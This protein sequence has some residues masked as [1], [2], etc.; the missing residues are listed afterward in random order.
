MD[1]ESFQ[2]APC[3]QCTYCRIQ[4]AAS[5]AV[6]L[7]HEYSCSYAASFITLTYEDENLPLIEHESMFQPT[8]EPD[9][10]TKFIKQLRQTT[11]SKI[12]YFLTG[13]YGDATNR[14]HYHAILFN[15]PARTPLPRR[16]IS[17]IW[18][19]GSSHIGSVTYESCRYVA[20][21]VQKKWYGDPTQSPHYP[22]LEPF[23]RMS[24][25]LGLKFAL[26]NE[27]QLLNNAGTTIQGQPVSLPRYYRKK[28]IGD[29]PEKRIAYNR[30]L[31]ER[32]TDNIEL[33]MNRLDQIEK[34]Q[35]YHIN[36]ATGWIEGKYMDHEIA[37][38]SKEKG[39]RQFNENLESKADKYQGGTL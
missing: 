29:D 9:H 1:P 32:E 26:K 38:R 28:L 19:Y 3:G 25:G 14:P 27:K 12:K 34:S 2:Q 20:G 22:A 31:A 8:L 37:E 5:W 4:R 39:R 7:M 16:E 6:R 30:K 15:Y 23:A 24:Q 11:T 21:Y 36:Q 10:M 35:Q 18:K 13:E 17:D 33:H